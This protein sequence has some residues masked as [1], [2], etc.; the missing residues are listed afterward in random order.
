MIAIEFDAASYPKILDDPP[1]FSFNISFFDIRS[2]VSNILSST[3]SNLKFDAIIVIKV[4]LERYDG[5][6][7]LFALL[8]KF[9]S[10]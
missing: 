5:H 6:S 2:L 10:F 8:L 1:R 9:P 7:F 3:E 4:G